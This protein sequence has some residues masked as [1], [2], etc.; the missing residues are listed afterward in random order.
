M[1]D[2]YGKYIRGGVNFSHDTA[3]SVSYDNTNSGLTA[4]DTQAAIDEL[5]SGAGGH[6]IVD[7]GDTELTQRAKLKFEGVYSSDN[8]TD[9]ETNVAVVRE[10]TEA[11][12]ALL[13]DDEKKGIILTEND[14]NPSLLTGDMIGY[15]NTTSGL[16]ATD[17][18][19][20]IDELANGVTVKRYRLTHTSF[21]W[22]DGSAS[23]VSNETLTSI[24]GNELFLGMSGD[25]T[26]GAAILGWR[27]VNGQGNI[28]VMGWIP[29][30]GTNIDSAY[31]FE[32]FILTKPST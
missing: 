17:I 24:I 5:A 15:D 28:Q 13:T 30:N 21:T 1:P 31:Q 18:Q 11:Q 2:T 25:F 23:F 7:D 6:V 16:V 8:A 14:R 19:D 27:V 12:Y 4:T 29:K 22:S 10:M 3:E 20:A 32:L 26:N 9:E